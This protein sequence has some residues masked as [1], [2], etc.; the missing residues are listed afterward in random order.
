MLINNNS[1]RLYA[2]TLFVNHV[3]T[4]C[5]RRTA[6]WPAMDTHAPMARRNCLSKYFCG[7]VSM[8]MPIQTRTRELP[9]WSSHY[10]FHHPHFSTENQL[11]ATRLGFI[12]DNVVKNYS[13]ECITELHD[14]S[15][16]SSCRANRLQRFLRAPPFYSDLVQRE[17]QQSANRFRFIVYWK[18]HLNH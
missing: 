18:I 15:S 9:F 7:I 12:A 13:H 4:T 6:S 2:A 14:G 11:P 8:F 17:F 1:N 10:S 3:S 16:T 5:K